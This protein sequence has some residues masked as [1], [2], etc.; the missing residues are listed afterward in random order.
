M[1]PTESNAPQRLRIFLRD[2][3]VLDASAR[4]PEGQSLAMYL[5]SRSRYVN[6]TAVDW[7]GTGS[8][9]PHM[10]LKVDHVLWVSSEDGTLPLTAAMAGAT[11]RR[12][13]VELEGGYLLAAGLLL[14]ENQRLTDYLHSAPPFIPLRDAELR[15]RRRPLGDIAVNQGAIQLVREIRAEAAGDAL[16]GSAPGGR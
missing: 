3:R 1:N 7:V 5:A 16:R 10:A 14:I 8:A 13:Q 6:L 4:V 12:V 2:H 11:A 15:P 9:V